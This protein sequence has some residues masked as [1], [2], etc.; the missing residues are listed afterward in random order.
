MSYQVRPNDM[1]VSLLQYLVPVK[2]IA[3]VTF[4]VAS[5]H[6]GSPLI[7]GGGSC[8][9]MCCRPSFRITAVK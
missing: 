3:V 4:N 1:L 9:C 2:A 5:W 8:R 7:K 6:T